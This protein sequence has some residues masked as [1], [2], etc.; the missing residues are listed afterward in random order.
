LLVELHNDFTLRYFPRR[1][2]LE[3]F[4][5]RQIRVQLDSREVPAL[6]VEDEL[7]LICVHGAKHLWERL[8]W[9][10][11]VAALVSRQMNLD[12]NLAASSAK[13]V[14]AERMLRVGLQLAETLKLRLPDHVLEMVQSDRVATSLTRQILNWRPAGGYAPPGL[15]E[16]AAFR[17]RMRGSL[18]Y[19]PS[20]LMRLSLS[21]TE[22]DWGAGAEDKRHWFLDALRRPF[23]LARKYGRDGKL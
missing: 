11:D 20:Y 18:I 12:W 22:E 8:M 23:R 4:F 16:S 17:L 13:E 15:F 5:E 9:I 1:L 3:R 2:S 21:P 7:V 10:A 19:A 14:G 6:S